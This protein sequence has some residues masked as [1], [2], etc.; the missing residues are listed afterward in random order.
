LHQEKITK[1]NVEN[2]KRQKILEINQQCEEKLFKVL[3]ANNSASNHL[4]DAMTLT[5]ATMK[6]FSTHCKVNELTAFCRA[7][8]LPNESNAIIQ[9][10]KGKLDEALNGNEN[11]IHFAHC[12][13]NRPPHLKLVETPL[14]ETLLHT[15]EPVV[16]RFSL[17]TQDL[18]P[19][20]NGE[21]SFLTN[22]WVAAALQTFFFHDSSIKCNITIS[23]RD[24]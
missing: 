10:K 7:R 22:E 6:D 20:I 2:H 16:C 13:R 24:R 19:T 21:L 14:L 5:R 8:I 4:T 18:D 15:P 1:I 3:G 11:L 23:V 17:P 9:K 12:I